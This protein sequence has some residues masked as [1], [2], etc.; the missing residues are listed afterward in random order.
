M[1]RL[2]SKVLSRVE[3]VLRSDSV[4]P[5]SHVVREEN[6]CLAFSCSWS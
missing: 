3:Q 6:R 1:K 2:F 4:F 5:L